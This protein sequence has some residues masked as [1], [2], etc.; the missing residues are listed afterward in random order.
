M[1]TCALLLCAGSVLACSVPVFRYA[2]DRWRPDTFVLEV[3][4]PTSADEHV[5]A[6]IRNHSDSSP[7]NLE[8]VARQDSPLSAT[9]LRFP[10]APNEAPE[11]WSGQLDEQTLARLTNSPARR[12]IA[13]RIV[14]GDSAVW[15]LVEKGGKAANDAIAARLEKRL[16]YLE[17][18]AQLPYIDPADPTS[19]LEMGPPLRIKFSIVRIAEDDLAEGP[20]TR[21]LA[22]PKADPYLDQTS[23][24]AAVFGR[25]RVLGAWSAEGF[26]SEQIDEV[27]LFLLG[28]CS[29]QVKNLNPGW[30][31]LMSMDWDEELIK[32]AEANAGSPAVLAPTSPVPAPKPPGATGPSSTNA[33]APPPNHEAQPET[34]MISTTPEPAPPA[35]V[36]GT[37]PGEDRMALILGGAF[38]LLAGA[39]VWF[40]SRAK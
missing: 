8:L 11:V 17:S 12:E 2:L 6:F 30:D 25:G 37:A 26:G 4:S 36:P 33:A 14:N 9:R 15:V 39:V 21:M 28:A 18:V 23:W 24:L 7:L 34:V 35:P 1:T 13:K 3:P 19:K 40:K 5:S 27:C 10:G 29:C 38:A 20:F 16:R 22:G 31:V 32:V